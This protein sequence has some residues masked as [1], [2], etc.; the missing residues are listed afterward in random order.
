MTETDE[1]D[2]MDETDEMDETEDMEEMDET[3]GMTK[4]LKAE[5]HCCSQCLFCRW[6]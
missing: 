1:M 3:D 5:N 6:C 2:K 4:L